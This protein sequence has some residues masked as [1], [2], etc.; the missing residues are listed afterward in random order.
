MSKDIVFVGGSHGAGKSTLCME[1][2][3]QYNVAH[4]T[5]SALIRAQSMLAAS[6]VIP[7]VRSNQE[8]LI[9]AIEEQGIGENATL[10][11]GHF[12]L[13]ESQFNI[14]EVPVS[15]FDTISPRAIVFVYCA[16]DLIVSR[17]RARDRT[18]I[19]PIDAI[20]SLQSTEYR[21]AKCV[22]KRLQCDMFTICSDTPIPTKEL[23]ALAK[24]LGLEAGI[25]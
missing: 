3:R 24:S 25:Q 19:I 6:R 12:C 4:V 16:P 8:L 21:R 22:S 18:S 23:D 5:A 13:F 7:D 11:D 1:L 20:R 10:L 9:A 2:A 17:I 15:T 14:R